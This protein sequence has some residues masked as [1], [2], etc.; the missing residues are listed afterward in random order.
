[1]F[2]RHPAS[3]VNWIEENWF[4]VFLDCWKLVAAKFVYRLNDGPFKIIAHNDQFLFPDFPDDNRQLA[5]V[6]CYSR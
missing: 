1:M 4:F 2:F 5:N 6:R 3:I